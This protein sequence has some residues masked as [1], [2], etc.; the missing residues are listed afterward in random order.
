[1]KNTRALYVHQVINT[2]NTARRPAQITLLAV[3]VRDR[4]S[5]ISIV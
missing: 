2:L 5:S 4:F 3:N 1:M